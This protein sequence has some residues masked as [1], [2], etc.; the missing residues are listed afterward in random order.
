MGGIIWPIMLNQ[1]SRVTSFA[2]SI[3]ATAALTA[4]LLIVAN[5]VVKF[6]PGQTN[7]AARLNVRSIFGDFPYMVS[8]AS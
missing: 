1:L 3:R 6:K 7:A 4:L 2:N 8:I 5:L